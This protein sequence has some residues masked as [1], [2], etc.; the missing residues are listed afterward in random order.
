MVVL[1]FYIEQEYSELG[2]GT[3]WECDV[4]FRGEGEQGTKGWV[5]KAEGWLF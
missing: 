3:G 2:W 5:V 4:V 1:R